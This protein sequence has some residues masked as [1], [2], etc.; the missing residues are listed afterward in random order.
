MGIVN[1]PMLG[2]HYDYL[3]LLTELDSGVASTEKQCT[4][5]PNSLCLFAHNQFN[6]SR[7]TL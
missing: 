3:M 4:K 7:S 2:T 5:R 6:V 1:D